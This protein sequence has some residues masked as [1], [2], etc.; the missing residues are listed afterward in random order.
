MPAVPAGSGPARKWPARELARGH[1]R[2]A[3]EAGAQWA[4]RRSRGCG[5]SCNGGT[6]RCLRS[7]S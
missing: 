1:S 2:A 5:V 3:E 7:P 4:L 6:P